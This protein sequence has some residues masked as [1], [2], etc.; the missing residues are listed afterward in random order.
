MT[1][2]ILFWLFT[3]GSV[4]GTFIEG[5]FCLIRYRRW[6]T[7]TVAIWGPFC[8]I[9]GAGAV[10]LYI[11]A[12]ITQNINIIGQFAFFATITTVIEYIGGM[13]LKR[14]LHMKAW[15]YSGCVLNVQVLICLKMS[16][17]WGALGVLFKEYVVP[18]IQAAAIVFKCVPLQIL[19]Y[20]MSVLMALNLLFTA[21]CIVRWARRHQGYP[22]KDKT[23]KYIDNKYNDEWMARRFCEWKFLDDSQTR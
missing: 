11:G 14:C 3:I 12:I 1:Y 23:E 7:H 10:A 19:T 22:P 2:S 5:V 16:I 20:I 9:Y 8:I 21:K 17:F 6:E 18:Y 15:D 4:L 13:L